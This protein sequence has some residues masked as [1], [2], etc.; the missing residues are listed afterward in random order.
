M[1]S[2]VK[3]RRRWCE[4]Q[5]T[6]AGHFLAEC[7]RPWERRASSGAVSACQAL[8]QDSWTDTAS[9][10]P[11]EGVPPTAAPGPLGA[12]RPH[13]TLRQEARGAKCRSGVC[14]RAPPPG[15]RSPATSYFTA[16]PAENKCFHHLHKK[17]TGNVPSSRHEPF[18]LTTRFPARVSLRLGGCQ[19]LR[20]AHV[21]G[22]VSSL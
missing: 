3:R 13:R 1:H 18:A 8:R 22:S 11:P 17:A 5:E 7:R 15:T 19:A 16:K 4:A 20:C 6:H 10:G 9:P 2:Q 14:T 21:G 12:N